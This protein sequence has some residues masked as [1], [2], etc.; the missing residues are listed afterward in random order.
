MITHCFSLT[1]ETKVEIVEY[2]MY[3]DTNDR[4][5]REP[6]VVHF[7]MTINGHGEFH[8]CTLKLML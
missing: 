2:F 7:K 3:N 5:E 1:S 4:F 6:L 8:L